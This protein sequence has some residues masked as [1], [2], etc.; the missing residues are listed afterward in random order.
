MD[1][2]YTEAQM[3]HNIFGEQNVFHNWWIKI[4]LPTVFVPERFIR[5]LQQMTYVLY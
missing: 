3:E 1:E 2:D 4:F 5:H